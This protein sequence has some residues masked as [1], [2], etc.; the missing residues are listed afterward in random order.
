M[1]FSNLMD[2]PLLIILISVFISDIW[3]Y[4]K[5][6]LEPLLGLRKIKMSAEFI[7]DGIL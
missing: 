5:Q 7:C 4:F 3:W 1:T 2:T 6:K